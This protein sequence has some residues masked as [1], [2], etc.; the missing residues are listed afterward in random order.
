M[1]K[2]YSVQTMWD[3]EAGVLVATSDDVPGL[4][5]EA[6]DA[7]ALIAKLQVM[8]PEMLFE[9]RVLDRGHKGT[10]Q[11]QVVSPSGKSDVITAAA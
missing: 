1:D 6:P 10:I 7:K 9:N 2:V 11:F 5:T 8:V 3:P 4:V